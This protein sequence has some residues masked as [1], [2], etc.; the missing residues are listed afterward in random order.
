MVVEKDDNRN[1]FVDDSD[2]EE[3]N[4]SK[5]A[6]NSSS[7]PSDPYA[8]SFQLKLG[9]SQATNLYYVDYN[10]RK[11]LDVEERNLLLQ[12]IATANATE[13]SL[14]GTLKSTLARADK[15]LSE[16]TNEVIAEQLEIQGATVQ[17]L[18]KNVQ[19]AMKLKV[20]EKH[21]QAIKR[22]IQSMAAQ[23]RR[24]KRLCMDF[25]IAL[26]ENTDGA[27]RAKKCL[28][29]DGPIALDS[30]EIVAKSAVEYAKNKRARQSQPTKRRR[31]MKSSKTK[32]PN[33]PTSLADEDFVAVNLDSQ[34][35]VC[36]IYVDDEN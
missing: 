9:K 26:E 21:K 10:K 16:P 5:A 27:V 34:H 13:E 36:R 2:N 32:K 12:N 33:S 15:L 1:P 35:C 31:V 8:G 25:L 29:G 28:S 3:E 6:N 17:K 20:N 22:K 19:E 7:T 18:E 14:K 4:S 11:G 23:W 30:D 24:R